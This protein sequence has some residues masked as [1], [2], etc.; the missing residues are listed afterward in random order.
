M[1]KTNQDRHQMFN[2]SSRAGVKT[3]GTA[4]NKIAAMKAGKMG[5]SIQPRAPGGLDG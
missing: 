1:Y 3:G 4:A 2:K 5:E